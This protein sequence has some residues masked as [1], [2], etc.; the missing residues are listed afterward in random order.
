[1]R[2]TCKLSLPNGELAINL[3]AKEK[4]HRLPD[5]GARTGLWT[6]DFA[7]CY[8]IA[9]QFEEL[10]SDMKTAEEHPEAEVTYLLF[11]NA[12]PSLHAKGDW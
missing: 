9:F 6:F 12:K 3:A 4:L 7:E 2:I 8:H 5:S 11:L 10:K 1:L